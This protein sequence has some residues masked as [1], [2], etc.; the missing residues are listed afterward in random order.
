[1]AE[2]NIPKDIVNSLKSIFTNINV[3]RVSEIAVAIALC[4]VG[5]ILARV[6]SNTFIR[7]IGFRFNAHQRLVWRRG[8]FYFIFMIFIMASLKEAGF[9]LSVFLGAAGILTVALGFASQ[10]S[11]SNLISGLFLIGEGSFEVGD[12]IQI[13]LIRGHTIEGEVIS[14]DLL[15]VKLLT[16]DNVYVRL[17]NE[18]LI[19]AP[20]HNL[21][22]FPIRRLSITV[23]INFNE[24]INKVREV[25]I[26]V[27]NAYPLVLAD[28]KPRVT[29]SAFGES[30]IEILFALWCK[31][32]N[33]L[34]VKDEIHELIRNRFVERHIEIPVP[35]IGFVDRPDTHVT[36][37]RDEDVDTY[38]NEQEVKLEKK[39]DKRL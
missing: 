1:M 5:F 16:M 12:T 27:A 9:K 39:Q 36:S 25:L 20:V 22:K 32:S 29:V 8:I 26:N 31:Q 28:P 37:T 21:S 10:T 23:A 30:S 17:P 15:S 3:D 6:V 38:A 35:K 11:A 19:R 18:Q 7:T 33:Y 13:T 34:Q 24:D 14:I 4:F 2:S